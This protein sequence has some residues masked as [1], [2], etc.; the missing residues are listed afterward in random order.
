MAN[1]D[2]ILHIFRI[3]ALEM[4]IFTTAQIRELDKYTIE[5]EPIASLELMERA[6]RAIA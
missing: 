5:H 1:S 2:V 4:K 3:F 6:A